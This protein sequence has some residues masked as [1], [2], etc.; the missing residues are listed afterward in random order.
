[1]ARTR[2]RAP[3]LGLS[4]RFRRSRRQGPSNPERFGRGLGTA[5]SFPCRNG[6]FRKST[7]P[8]GYWIPAFAGMTG[9]GEATPPRLTAA[10]VASGPRIS[11]CSSGVTSCGCRETLHPS[12]RHP[13]RASAQSR[14]LLVSR[15]VAGARRPPQHRLAHTVLSFVLPDAGEAC[16]SGIGE[17]R[18]VAAALRQKRRA[19]C[20]SGPGSRLRLPGKTR[21]RGGARGTVQ[22]QR[23]DRGRRQGSEATG[24][25][26]GEREDRSAGRPLSR[27]RSGGR[28]AS[29]RAA[30]P[31][32]RSAAASAA[33]ARPAPAP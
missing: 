25:R 9:M 33:P 24:D 32:W 14:G 7:R 8:G 20:L 22:G 3:T 26:D 18:A 4:S 11:R 16:R 1:M 21:G 31:P 6:R 10:R 19:P 23:G 28:A 17:P 30:G 2:R 5:V 13:G 12:G 29:A 27:C 15:A